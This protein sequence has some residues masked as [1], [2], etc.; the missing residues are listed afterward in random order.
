MQA[1]G[2]HADFTLGSRVFQ[3]IEDAL[4]G[5]EIGI[6]GTVCRMHTLNAMQKDSEPST[7]LSCVPGDR[8]KEIIQNWQSLWK[9]TINSSWDESQTCA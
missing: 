1:Y 5:Y 6:L 2:I 4:Q 8:N 7:S 9:K 3:E